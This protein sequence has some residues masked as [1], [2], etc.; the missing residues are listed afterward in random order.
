MSSVWSTSFQNFCY[1][2][3]YLYRPI[4]SIKNYLD[5]RKWDHIKLQNFLNFSFTTPKGTIIAAV[6]SVVPSSYPK[7]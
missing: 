7:N 4:N 2:C 3:S 5:P 1:A 6:N